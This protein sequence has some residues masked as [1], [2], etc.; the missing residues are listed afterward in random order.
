M[1]KFTNGLVV[2]TLVG[3]AV[4]AAIVIVVT[5]RPVVTCDDNHSIAVNPT[6]SKLPDTCSNRAPINWMAQT[7]SGN[8]TVQIPD[9]NGHTPTTT[10]NPYPAA[11]CSGSTCTSGPYTTQT[12]PSDT[13]IWYSITFATNS[14]RIYGRII[15]KP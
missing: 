11:N 12:I 15:I 1:S 8:I 6:M 13:A 9:W 7:G 10:I 2:G 5:R 14:Q 3:A 4:G